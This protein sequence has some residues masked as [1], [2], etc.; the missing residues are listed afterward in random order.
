MSEQTYCEKP[1]TAA[2][3]GS[4]GLLYCQIKFKGMTG[5]ISF[6]ARGWRNHFTLDVVEVLYG[7][8]TKIGVWDSIDGINST[9]TYEE[10]LIE[11]EKSIQNKTFIIFSKIV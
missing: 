3:G 8:I 6:D 5:E 4:K 9:K 11:I 10:K 1:D 7:G 2:V